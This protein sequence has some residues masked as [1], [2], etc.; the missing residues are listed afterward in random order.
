MSARIDLTGAPVLVT[1]ATGGLGSAVARAL[2]AR[3]A[4]PLLTGRRADVLAH[5]AAETGG[6]AV[7]VD[8]AEPADVERLADEAAA[9]RVL[10]LNAALPGSGALDAYDVA[11]IDAVLDVNLRAPIVLC[12]RLVP[13]LVAAGTGHVVLMSSLAGKAANPSSSLY[14]ATKFGLRGFGLALRADLRGTGV[15]V[16]VVSPGFI[17]DAGMFHDSGATLPPG[18]G[19]RTPQDVAAAVLRAVDEDP[20][21]LDVAPLPLRAGAAVAGVAPGLAAA[22]ARRLG[23]DR[24]SRG[25][26]EGQSAKR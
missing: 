19:T 11:G 12:R 21:E 15:G 2:A 18:V 9:C 22:V 5:L 6:R 24:V 25:I 16:T 3:G 14:S 23:A 13:G 17:R 10:V 4:A 20:A 1:G 8:L 26:G 7:A